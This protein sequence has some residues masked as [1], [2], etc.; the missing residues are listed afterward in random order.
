MAGGGPAGAA[1]AIALARAGR[2]VLL[3]E[4]A[5]GARAKVGEALPPAATPL[6]RD[7]GALRAVAADGHLPSYGNVARW[8]AGEPYAVD[9]LADPNGHGWHVDRARL[10]S[11]LREVAREAGATVRTETAAALVAGPSPWELDCGGQRVGA[12][13]FVDATGRRAALARTLGARRRRLDR[14]VAVHATLTA[15]PAE[16]DARTFVEAVPG[17]WWYCALV[18][19]GR[20]VA[21]FL[22]DAGAMPAGLRTAQGFL[23]AFSAT[24]LPGAGDRT[25]AEGP[26]AGA[27]HGMRL[28]AVAGDGWAAVGDAALACDPLSSQ[29]MVTALYTGL[30]AARAVHDFLDGA[31]DALAR[32]AAG[33]LRLA[34]DYEVNRR[35]TYAL[36]R[37][38][39]EQPF[40][41]A[42]HGL[43]SSPDVETATARRSLS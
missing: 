7:L 28:S 5:D 3:C 32:Y 29:G 12:R 24:A 13:A 27:A 6:L 34:A 8:G 25:L 15:D 40:W 2:S 41:A 33:V 31:G 10:E 1:A 36:E 23:D 4:A 18:P 35:R 20:R 22:T 30:C 42:R 19:G 37:R 43:G 11:R 21:A 16:H 14:L 9:F 26:R 17:G 38:W 39:P